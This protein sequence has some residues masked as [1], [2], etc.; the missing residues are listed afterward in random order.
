MTKGRLNERKIITAGKAV[1]ILK[2]Y[3]TKISEEEAEF[4]LDF[5]YKMSN[6][7]VGNFNK[8]NVKQGSPTQE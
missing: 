8:S 3:G 5:M 4:I 1:E 6:L 7:T 2:R